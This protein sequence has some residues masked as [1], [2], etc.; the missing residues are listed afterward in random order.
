[1]LLATA[2]LASSVDPLELVEDLVASP[3]DVS[4]QTSTPPVKL[5]KNLRRAL[6]KALVDLEAESAEQQQQQQQPPAKAD[7]DE[8]PRTTGASVDE[9][10]YDFLEISKQK[11]A[12]FSFDGFPN[13]EEIPSEDKLQNSSFVEVD[14]YAHADSQVEPERRQPDKDYADAVQV[15]DRKSRLLC[16]FIFPRSLTAWIKVYLPSCANLVRKSRAQT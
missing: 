8:E 13:E 5:D 14:K 9:S 16:T 15:P 6:L 2:V 7:L 4:T 12:S 3:S 1:V 11:S 10:K